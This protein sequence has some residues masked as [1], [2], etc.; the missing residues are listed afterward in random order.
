MLS[1]PAL[2]VFNG[3]SEEDIVLSFDKSPSPEALCF[4]DFYLVVLSPPLGLSSLV[5]SGNV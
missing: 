2:K 1:L 4:D 5:H 3:Y